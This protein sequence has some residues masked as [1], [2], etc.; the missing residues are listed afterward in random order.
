M[1][2]WRS[3]GKIVG[4]T[5]QNLFA[6]PATIDY[7]KLG[8]SPRVEKNYRGR[9]QYDPANCVNCGLC[10][11]DCPTG[12]IRIVNDGTKEEKKMR[13]VLDTGRCVFCCQCVDSC[14][15]GCLSFSQ[16]IDL[17]AEKKE[18]LTVN[19]NEQR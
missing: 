16:E 7:P 17:C 13:A 12:A 8:E 10:M 4:L 9:L 1:N 14:R 2:K 15:K 5:L 6:K 11:R 19:L 18:E 3:P